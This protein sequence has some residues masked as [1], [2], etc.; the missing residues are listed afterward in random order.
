MEIAG[1]T[2]SKLYPGSWSEWCSDPRRPMEK[3]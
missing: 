3:G 1:L 2:G